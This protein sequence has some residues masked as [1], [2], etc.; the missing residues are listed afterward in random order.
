MLHGVNCRVDVRP[1]AT[2]AL[3]S[4]PGKDREAFHT[5]RNTGTRFGTA[6]GAQEFLGFPGGAATPGERQ[7]DRQLGRG[8]YHRFVSRQL[9]PSTLIHRHVAPV[10]PSQG[11]SATSGQQRYMSLLFMTVKLHAKSF[12]EELAMAGGR[13]S[14]ARIVTRPQAEQRS[15]QGSIPSR[16][17]KFFSHA[18]RP[19][20]L[21][22]PPSPLSNGH[23][24]LFAVG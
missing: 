10:H 17:N 20:R 11:H 24:G 23:R 4:R 16:V 19:D 15:N 8:T 6:D 2:T 7:S 22:G 14:L 1:E 13:D 3:F 18:K 12:H 21:Q 9:V 5:S